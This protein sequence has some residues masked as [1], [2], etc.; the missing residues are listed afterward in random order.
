MKFKS[1]CIPT[2]VNIVVF[3]LLHCIFYVYQSAN[4]V[5]V[6]QLQNVLAKKLLF[7]WCRHPKLVRDGYVLTYICYVL[8]IDALNKAFHTNEKNIIFL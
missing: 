7:R 6:V 8:I 4:T 3:V 1:K 5:I 2:R